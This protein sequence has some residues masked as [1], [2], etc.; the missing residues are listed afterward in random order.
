[1]ETLGEWFNDSNVDLVAEHGAWFKKQHTSWHK[2]PGLSAQWK[3]EIL[4][5]LETYVDRTPGTFIEEKTYSLVWHYRKAQKGLGELRAGEL[6]NNLKYLATDKGLQLLPGDKVV[7][8]KN[9]EINKGKAAL[10]LIDGK[11]YDFIMAFGDDYTDEDIFKA[12][13]ESAV[14]IK[15]GSNVSA[16]KFYLRNPVEARR[17]LKNLTENIVVVDTDK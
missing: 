13:P 2:L 6:M 15:I 3:N 16:A 17:L 9:I 14:T 1:H 4:P 12:L 10:T 5:V 7:E 11:N 8:V